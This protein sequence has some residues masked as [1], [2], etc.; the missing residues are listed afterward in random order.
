MELLR[1]S[2]P[3]YFWTSIGLAVPTIALGA[4]AFL[5]GFGN[6]LS[7]D[8]PVRWRRVYHATLGVTLPLLAVT[9]ALMIRG[10]GLQRNALRPLGS[11]RTALRRERKQ[12][13][14][15]G[16]PRP[17]PGPVSRVR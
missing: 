16:S 14:R 17:E 12:I 11:R 9:L 15:D 7:P 13:V 6:A 1:A 4:T 10:I 8:P 2:D 5:Y 3:S